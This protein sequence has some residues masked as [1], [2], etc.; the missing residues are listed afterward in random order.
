[1]SA[2]PPDGAA[3]TMLICCAG[4]RDGGGWGT[5]FNLSWLFCCLA[6]A[7]LPSSVGWGC[8]RE[9]FALAVLPTH[10]AAMRCGGSA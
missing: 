9:A 6:L 7:D 2:V 8:F 5:A 1:M 3:R 4:Q 10:R